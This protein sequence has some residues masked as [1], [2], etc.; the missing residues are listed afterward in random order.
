MNTESVVSCPWSV[1]KGEA[2]GIGSAA[3]ASWL[4][5]T[6]EDRGQTTDGRGQKEKH[7]KIFDSKIYGPLPFTTNDSVA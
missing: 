3:F 2:W 1:A 6:K 4:R 5:R 7:F